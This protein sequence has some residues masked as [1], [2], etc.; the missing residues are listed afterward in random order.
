[1]NY[2]QVLD[3]L[4]AQLPMFYRDGVAAY[5]ANLDNTHALC[6]LLNHPE[7][8]FKNIHVAGTNGKG[9]SSHMLAA[10]LQ[11]AG[12]KTGLYTSPHLK[13]F[14]ERIRINGQMIPEAEVLEF[15]ETYK[16][17]FDRIKPSFFEW[18]VALCFNYFRTQKIDI[19]V[20]ET[21][22]GGRLDSTN[23]I[24][25]E[26]SLITN[27]AFDHMALLGDSL[28]KIA[29]EKAGII[30]A[31]KPVVISQSQPEIAQVFINKSNKL[32][33]PIFFAEQHFSLKENNKS[34]DVYLNNHLWLSDL[35]LDLQGVYQQKN[36]LGVLQSVKILQDQAW[37]ISKENIKEGLAQVQKLTGLMGRWQILA[38]APLI[39]ADTAHNEDGVKNMLL[40]LKKCRF[41]NLHIVLGMVH[42]KDISSVL[43]QLPSNATYY[44]CKA[45][46][47]RAKNA[48]D[49]QL[50]AEMFNLSGTCF[51]SVAAA[52]AAAKQK[53]HAADLILITGSNFTVAEVL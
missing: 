29:G 44:F 15:A 31:H 37:L 14:R 46:I 35:T 41:T 16:V 10:I 3:Y 12:Y 11:S 6:K 40:Q 42:D 17:H 52:F 39:V 22:L 20:I 36:L 53:A 25:P 21:G 8:A 30:K 23:V 48:E 28:E 49:L 32:E 7:K 13:D 51:T 33:A 4:Y 2:Q 43:K 45:N 27:I 19:A 5:K 24:D 1:M 50:E 38:N 26:L 34:V 47:P 9:S 18:T